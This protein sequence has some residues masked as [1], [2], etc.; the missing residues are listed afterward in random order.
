MIDA[1]FSNSPISLTTDELAGVN[2]SRRSSDSSCLLTIDD[3][4]AVSGGVVVCYG[5]SPW[6]HPGDGAPPVPPGG[7][8]P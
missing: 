7:S 1:K 5:P 2:T 8:L 3:L 4:A 6:R